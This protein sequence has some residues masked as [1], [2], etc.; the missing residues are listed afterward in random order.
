MK[1]RFQV[2]G[3]FAIFPG[4]SA[5][6]TVDTATVAADRGAEIER[7]V[8]EV[9]EG[10]GHQAAAASAPA[11]PGGFGGEVGVPGHAGGAGAPGGPAGA[12]Q[13]TYTIEVLDDDGAHPLAS[14]TDPVGDPSLGTLIGKLSELRTEGQGQTG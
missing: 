8:A 2:S 4:L 9:R 7:L 3:G 13:R 10:V 12:D 6:F 14:A 11:G 1:L 5:P